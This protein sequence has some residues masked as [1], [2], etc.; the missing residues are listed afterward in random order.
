MMRDAAI[1]LAEG[2]RK[3]DGPAILEACKRL[4]NSCVECHAYFK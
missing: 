3:K 2:A 1:E 4:E